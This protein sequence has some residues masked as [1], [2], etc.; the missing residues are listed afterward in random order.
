MR[1]R[2]RS[3][4]EK[5]SATY[6]QDGKLSPLLKKR[7]LVICKPVEVLTLGNSSH[8]FVDT[9]VKKRLP[10]ILKNIIQKNSLDWKAKGKAYFAM[11]KMRLEELRQEVDEN[12]YGGNIEIKLL[13]DLP[14]NQIWNG[15]YIRENDGKKLMNISTFFLE[16]YFYRRILDAV[17]YWENKIDPFTL[18]KSELIDSSYEP[19]KKIFDRV[20]SCRKA[21]NSIVINNDCGAKY[22]ENKASLDQK[23]FFRMLLHYQLWGNRADLSLSAGATDVPSANKEAVSLLVDDSDSVLDMLM[24]DE[25][26]NA[27][28]KVIIVLDN[29]G[30]ELLCDLLF[31]NSLLTDG[32]CEQVELH[33]KST[34]VFVSD[35]LGKDIQQTIVWLKSNGFASLSSSLHTSIEEGKLH[36][37]DD[38]EFYTSPLSYAEMPKA[39]VNRFSDADLVVIKGDANYRRLL[40]ERKWRLDTPFKDALS[41]FQNTNILALRTLKWP[42]A[43]GLDSKIVD[44]AKTQIGDEWDICGRCGTIQYAQFKNACT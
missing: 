14:Q 34:P 5:T 4:E 12:C 32:V 33:C 21:G 16:N 35:A 9:T 27:N 40:G 43:V 28:R 8:K 13:D 6:R 25:G 36:I 1:K 20:S 2:T 41:Y 31:A 23:Q 17:L 39:L 18:H 22:N 26:K 30:L 38:L 37:I 24:V 10:S 11:T 42:L 7:A 44:H 19:F 29:C 3:E 15:E